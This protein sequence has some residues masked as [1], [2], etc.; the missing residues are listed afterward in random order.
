MSDFKIRI[1][2][3]ASI[4]GLILSDAQLEFLNTIVVKS[5]QN[6][7]SEFDALDKLFDYLKRNS[8]TLMAESKIKIA[9]N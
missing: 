6:G 4:I 5:I 8:T 2:N 3:R 9:R 1:Q 7:S